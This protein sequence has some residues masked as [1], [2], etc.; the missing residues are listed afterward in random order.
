MGLITKKTYGTSKNILIGQES[1]SYS[2]GVIV[3]NTG[4]SADSDGKKII[5]AGTPIGG[6]TSVL[7]NRQEPMISTNTS[8]NG[9]LAQGIVLHD[10]DVTEGNANATMVVAGVV[11]LLKLEDAPVSQA[12]AVLT[13]IIFVEGSAI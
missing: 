3:A 11:D 5:K 12:T 4:L 9:A 8:G 1:Y 2:L 6:S 10:V 7:E 13:K